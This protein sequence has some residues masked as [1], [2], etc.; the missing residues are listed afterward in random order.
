MTNMQSMISELIGRVD[1]D[2]ESK[3]INLLSSPGYGDLAERIST[4]CR[5]P[6]VVMET[7]E[8]KEPSHGLHIATTVTTRSFYIDD[9]S[10]NG[11]LIMEAEIKLS[12]GEFKINYKYY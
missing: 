4:G 7:S 6:K 11:K 1:R 5:F 2:I 8:R 10:I 9:G 12:A 3:L